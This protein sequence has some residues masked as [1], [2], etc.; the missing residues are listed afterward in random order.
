MGEKLS[1]RDFLKVSGLELFLLAMATTG[2]SGVIYSLM[3]MEGWDRE[4]L[5]RLNYHGGEFGPFTEGCENIGKHDHC[6]VLVHPH[7]GLHHAVG[8]LD[9]PEYSDY[10]AGLARLTD[11]LSQTNELVILWEEEEVLGEEEVAVIETPAQ[12]LLRVATQRGGGGMVHFIL[13]PAGVLKQDS[14]AVFKILRTVG[15]QEGW[16]V[17]SE[18]GGCV[19]RAAKYFLKNELAIRGV[20]GLLFPLDDQQNLAPVLFSNQVDPAVVLAGVY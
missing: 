3:R 5:N 10:L 2:L 13:T 16:F 14:T 17:G 6:W 7:Y 15:V 12:C 4:L 9:D 8:Y 11:A 18:P 20:K 19:S 1:R